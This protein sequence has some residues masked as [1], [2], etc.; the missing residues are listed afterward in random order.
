MAHT[1]ERDWKLKRELT[2][3]KSPNSF[4]SL[5]SLIII[6]HRAYRRRAM[7]GEVSG[8]CAS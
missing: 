2:E 8:L 1:L 4:D 7:R 3:E 6:E 5:F